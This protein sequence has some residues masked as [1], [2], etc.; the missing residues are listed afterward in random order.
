MTATEPCQAHC[1]GQLLALPGALA[2]HP[3]P[4][5]TALLSPWRCDLTVELLAWFEWKT[6]G[7][8]VGL[9]S[10][11]TLLPHLVSLHLKTK[12]REKKTQTD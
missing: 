10:F 12:A 2:S 5:S 7:T 6:L 11:P 3:C 4:L 9:S 8:G 1:R